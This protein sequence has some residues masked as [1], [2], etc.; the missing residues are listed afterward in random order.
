MPVEEESLLRCFL[1]VPLPD[2]TRRR[3]AAALP[4]ALPG[5]PVPPSNWHFTIRF[6]GQLASDA[7]EQVAGGID[8]AEL[9]GPFDAELGGLGA[10]PSA[11]RARTL[12]LGLNR[13]GAQFTRLAAAVDGV[14]AGLGVAAEAR[15]FS[16]H[17]TLARLDPPGDLTRLVAGSGRSP[18]PFRVDSLVLYRSELGQGPPRYTELKRIVLHR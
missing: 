14:L 18:I 6:L 12:W 7:V 2:S 17:L 8:R 16:P 4:G 15:P 3:L 9:P 11:A 10:F 1:A 5:R 13:G